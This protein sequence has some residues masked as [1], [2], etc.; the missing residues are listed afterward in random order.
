M[1]IQ[2][3]CEGISDKQNETLTMEIYKFRYIPLAKPEKI[4]TTNLILYRY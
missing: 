2:G 4:H 1:W 3:I